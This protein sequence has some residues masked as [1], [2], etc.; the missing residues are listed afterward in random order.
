[1]EVRRS[2]HL[3]FSLRALTRQDLQNLLAKKGK[4][5]L[6][7]VKWLRPRLLIS[8]PE[9][10][11]FDFVATFYHVNPTNPVLCGHAL[12]FPESNIRRRI[13]VSTNKSSPGVSY[14]LSAMWL[15]SKRRIEVLQVMR[16]KP[17]RCSSGGR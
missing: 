11:G 7:K 8:A 16:R 17:L 1:M 13:V 5:S 10:L 4:E 15:E 9:V 12:P 3:R 2:L 14:V 6:T